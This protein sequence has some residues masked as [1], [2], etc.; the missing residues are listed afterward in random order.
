M[1]S[2]VTQL[3]KDTKKP[4]EQT[5]DLGDMLRQ[6]ARSQQPSISVWNH[7]CKETQ[8]NIQLERG[9]TCPYCLIDENGNCQKGAV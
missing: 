6:I 2:N 4:V 5:N 7:A 3:F 9:L 8:G 1:M